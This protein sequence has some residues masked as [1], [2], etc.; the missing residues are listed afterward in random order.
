MKKSK[1]ISSKNL[2]AKIPIFQLAVMFLLLDKCNFSDLA[3][4]I[5]G[6]ISVLILIVAIIEVVKQK[7]VD[8]F[9]KDKSEK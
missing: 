9:E 6:T 3:I 7:E 2:P 8:I 5:I 4:G 1:V